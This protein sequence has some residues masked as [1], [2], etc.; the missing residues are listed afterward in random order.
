MSAWR[1]AGVGLSRS[2]SSSRSK[3]L[4]VGQ[5]SEVVAHCDFSDSNQSHEIIGWSRWLT[6]SADS[7]GYRGATGRHLREDTARQLGSVGILGHS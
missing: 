5:I 1:W 7:D 6:K 2:A 4:I 3:N